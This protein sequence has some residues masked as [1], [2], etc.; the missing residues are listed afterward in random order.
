MVEIFFDMSVHPIE[1]E[2]LGTAFLVHDWISS[3]LEKITMTQ[4]HGNTVRDYKFLEA[5]RKL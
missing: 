5:K 2:A 3:L 1:K 4:N